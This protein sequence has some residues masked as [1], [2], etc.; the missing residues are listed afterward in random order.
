M[1]RLLL[2]YALSN[3]VQSYIVSASTRLASSAPGYGDQAVLQLSVGRIGRVRHLQ[4]Q[5]QWV[6]D[7]QLSACFMLVILDRFVKPEVGVTEGL[8]VRGELPGNPP[9]PDYLT[10]ELF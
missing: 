9:P 8:L 7:L 1:L 6:R 10:Y 2:L 3:L 5:P 4:P